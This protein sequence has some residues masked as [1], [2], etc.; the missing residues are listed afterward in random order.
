MKTKVEVK[1]NLKDNK[2]GQLLLIA[3]SQGY[4]DGYVQAGD[5]QGYAVVVVDDAISICP[6]DILK[7][8]P[9]P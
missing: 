1:E 8:I 7:V 5:R 9:T 6:L 3:G 4:I 2:T